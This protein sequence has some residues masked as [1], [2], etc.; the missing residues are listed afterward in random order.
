V[1]EPAALL[2]SITWQQHTLYCSMVLRAGVHFA[3]EGE[4]ATNISFPD[5]QARLVAQ[6]AAAAKSPVVV[7]TITASALDL[8]PFLANPKV[9]GLLHAGEPA[10]S[11]S[12]LADLIFGHKVLVFAG[13]VCMCML[14]AEWGCCL[15]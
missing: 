6:V 8:E 13:C 12:G 14:S 5:A 4:D 15:R 3:S 2:A 11:S 7:V 10:D 9:G 1:F